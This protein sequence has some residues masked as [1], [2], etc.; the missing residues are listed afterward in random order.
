MPPPIWPLPTTPILRMSSEAPP[1]GNQQLIG[2]IRRAIGRAGGR[3][4]FRDYMELA[5][6]H[7][8][9]GYYSV[10]GEK[11]GKR[12]DYLTSPQ[13]SPLFAQC[14]ARFIG[15]GSVLEIGAGDGT[16]AAQLAGS[17]ECTA[18]ERNSTLPDRFDGTILSNELLD[19]L[20]VHR[21]VR[22]QERYVR[23]DFAEELGPFSTSRLDEYFERLGLEPAGE[24]EVNLDALDFM[25]S[26]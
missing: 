22:D 19:A 9:Y 20:P 4:P 15:S 18:L 16:L 24:A 23:T 25:S 2:E 26:V 8:R 12:G 14:L 1:Q 6:Y 17:F 13:V 7:P 11:T 5:L 21:V 10:P 3:I